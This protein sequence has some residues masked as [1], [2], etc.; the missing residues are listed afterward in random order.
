MT[1][2]GL[3][4]VREKARHRTIIDEAGYGRIKGG[5]LRTEGRKESELRRRLAGPEP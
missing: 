3:E 1:L 5:D 4:K 2:E